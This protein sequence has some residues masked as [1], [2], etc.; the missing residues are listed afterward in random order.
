MRSDLMILTVRPMLLEAR[1]QRGGSVLWSGQAEYHGRAELAD[2]IA[3]LVAEP[4]LV[5]PGRR[6]RVELARPVVQLRT[7]AD[8][9]PVRGSHLRALVEQQAHRYFRKNGVPLVLDAAWS[10]RKRRVT[11]HAA[12][13]EEPVVS[14]IV[15]GARAG[16]FHLENIT[17]ADSAGLSLLLTEERERRRRQ[18][19]LS[20]R[21]LCGAV[22]VLWIAVAVIALL[23]HGSQERRVRR[24]LAALAGPVSAL[25]QVRHEV[26][27]ATETIAAL[28]EA[29]AIRARSAGTLAA[30]TAALPDSAFLASLEI[31]PDGSG[32]LAGYAKRASEVLARLDAT[33]A[34]VAP[35]LENQRSR[36]TVAGRE[37][38]SFSIRF[39]TAKEPDAR[40]YGE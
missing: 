1:L 11:V 26:T 40:G 12:A 33:E 22:V 19:R 35:V 39:G 5:K 25:R 31:E 9:P 15:E 8:L 36:E 32:R 18:A 30:I 23:A 16:G 27:L 6:L 4:A 2:A 24:E 17:P 3:R 20:L 34:V 10:D 13:V 21:R 28:D 14:A 38:E 37:W 29:E 7:L